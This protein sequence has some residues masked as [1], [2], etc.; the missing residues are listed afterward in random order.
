MRSRLKPGLLGRA[1]MKRLAVEA[2]ASDLR[3]FTRACCQDDQQ[4]KLLSHWGD[5]VV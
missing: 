5:V 4:K 2:A 3:P 1:V